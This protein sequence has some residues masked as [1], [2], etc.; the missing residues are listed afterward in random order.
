M[1]VYP[2]MRTTLLVLIG[3][4]VSAYA[5]NPA[6]PPV[7]KWNDPPPSGVE[8]VKPAPP[9]WCAGHKPRPWLPGNVAYDE[10]KRG[11][12][13]DQLSQIAMLACDRPDDVGRQAWIAFYRQGWL[14]IVGTTD[15]EDREAMAARLDLKQQ[16][17]KLD[18]ACKPLRGRRDDDR[19][20]ADRVFDSLRY[21]ALGCRGV[22]TAIMSQL[23]ND[24]LATASYWLDQAAEPP[25][26]LVR[27]AFVLRCFNTGASS[28]DPKSAIRTLGNHAFCGH[29]ARKLDRKTFD[30]AVARYQLPPL[31]RARAREM[32]AYTQKLLAS[33]RAAYASLV[34]KD[35]DYA[36]LIVDEPERGF[37]EWSKLRAANQAALDGALAMEDKFRDGDKRAA[38]GCRTVL[39]K[40]LAD[41]VK[42]RDPKTKDDVIDGVNDD[43]G[44]PVLRALVACDALEGRFGIVDSEL[45]LL[46]QG[47]ER[48]GPRT[49]A[50]WHTL[51]VVAPIAKDNPKFVQASQFGAPLP[52]D[53]NL[54]SWMHKAH[55]S[56]L[57]NT[58][59]DRDQ[60]GQIA[61]MVASGDGFTIAFKHSSYQAPTWSCQDTNRIDRIT[62]DGRVE[63]RQSCVQTGTHTVNDTAQSAWIRKDVAE[64]LKVGM[65]LEMRL[66]RKPD[67]LEGFPMETYS[68]KQ[69]VQY[70][71]FP[72][73]KR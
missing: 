63:Y 29:D 72:L 61:S 14:N 25:D 45:K 55:E 5:N 66:D 48:R 69:L 56:T 1:S 4:T 15:A 24:S 2:S 23:D 50:F 33:Y 12:S 9:T 60:K 65:V 59:F 35:K 39:R 28:V 11:Y 44:Q 71:G 34:A 37:A 41:H 30:Q 38:A 3:C 67:P 54:G 51:D 32:F 27:L 22:P 19:S 52:S 68:A 8:T 36:T 42:S 20:P 21:A 53:N 13:E 62:P 70:W 64:G 6:D 16:E 17:A 73:T 7:A 18:A 40:Q 26:E 47:R 57:N 31:G 49:A 58:R 46:R 43:V 10:I